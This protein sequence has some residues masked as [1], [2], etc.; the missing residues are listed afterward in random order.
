M[1]VQHCLPCSLFK[2]WHHVHHCNRNTVINVLQYKQQSTWETATR[3]LL[4]RSFCEQRPPCQKGL[5]A[6][7]SGSY[8]SFWAKPEV[9]RT[10]SFCQHL[11][12]SLALLTFWLSHFIQ[13]H[14][15]RSAVAQAF[16]SYLSYLYPI[17]TAN[18]SQFIR[19]ATGFF[20]FKN[21]VDLNSTI[22]IQTLLWVNMCSRDWLNTMTSK[23]ESRQRVNTSIPTNL[24]TSPHLKQASQLRWMILN[25]K[26][27]SN[28]V[29]RIPS[30]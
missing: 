29:L 13:V 24:M 6:R 10:I 2:W 3:L 15:F 21:T 5:R 1:G 18:Q 4:R 27:K 7:W 11:P 30:S 22:S 8:S 12:A 25:R 20:C 23:Q 14:I 17:V 28:L 26:K 19:S 9:N 16:L